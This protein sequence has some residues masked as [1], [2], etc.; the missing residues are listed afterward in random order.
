MPAALCQQALLPIFAV[1]PGF[2][3]VAMPLWKYDRLPDP[4]LTGSHTP[5]N[6]TYIAAPSTVT[7]VAMLLAPPPAT[8]GFPLTRLG[9][10][11]YVA[12]HEPGS[13]HS[14]SSARPPEVLTPLTLSSMYRPTEIRW[15]ALRG[16]R[17]NGVE[18][19]LVV[20]SLASHEETS[21][22][23]L[24]PSVVTEMSP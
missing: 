6:G 22:Q 10:R 20:P 18:N 23:F 12:F 2:T 3:L 17:V 7:A 13:R 14:P 19:W 9:P 8:P 11:S 21:L 15:L 16:S 24:P 4:W 1:H 5:Q